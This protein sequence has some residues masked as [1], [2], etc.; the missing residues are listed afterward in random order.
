M[1]NSLDLFW[2]PHLGRHH[3][4]PEG[5]HLISEG[6]MIPKERHFDRQGGSALAPSLDPRLAGIF[7]RK[8]LMKSVRLLLILLFMNFVNKVICLRESAMFANSS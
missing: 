2:A 5:W 3:S 7:V 6:G 8:Q 1:K 4:K